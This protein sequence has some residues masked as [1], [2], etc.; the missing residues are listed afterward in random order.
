MN[1]RVVNLSFGTDS[2]QPYQ[3]TRSPPQRRTPGGTASCRG[4]L[5][6]Q[7][8][9][10]RR[11]PDRP[12]DGPVRHRGRRLDAE[13]GGGWNSP[14]VASF[15]SS[16]TASRHV[17]LVAPGTSI[18]SL[19]NPGSYIDANHPSGLV[20]GDT[21]GRLFRGSG[22]SQAAAVV[23]GAVAL[24]EQAPAITP[25]QVKGAPDRARATPMWRA[26]STAGAGE[27]NVA[28]RAAEGQHGGRA[29]SAAC[30]VLPRRR[31]RPSRPRPGT[32]SIEAARGGNTW[33]TRRRHVL[34]RGRRA[35]QAVERGGLVGRR[36]RRR[37]RV[38][39]RYVARRHVDRH[40]LGLRTGALRHVGSSARWCRHRVERAGWDSARWSSAR[41]SSAGGR[42]PAGQ[43]ARWSAAAWESSDHEALRPPCDVRACASLLAAG[44]CRC[45]PVTPDARRSSELPLP[46]PPGRLGAGFVLAELCLM[47][48]EFRRQALLV[49]AGRHPARARAAGAA[50][51][52]RGRHGVAGSLVAFAS[53][54][55]PRQSRSTTSPA[56]AF[57]AALERLCCTRS[58]GRRRPINLLVG[59][60]R[61][62]GRGRRP[63]DELLRRRGHPVHRAADRPGRCCRYCCRRL[64]CSLVAAP[65]R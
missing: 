19:R 18:T 49:H 11:P 7:R 8:G 16:G 38:D 60:R 59:V 40:R 51:A 48:V 33:S 54:A 3:S 56:Y 10:E 46:V 61:P 1:V 65:S 50:R 45:W 24:L 17:D 35:G 57:E 31:R 29:S 21:T 15:S 14:T 22:T 64:V 37:H 36:V 30:S 34:R 52:G 20:A 26:S 28:G 25:D 23:S 4:R 53:N 63:G 44:C 6:R 27:L 5:R 55:P 9:P 39:G 2:L 42:R 47:H 41:W 12:G 58:W 62:G 13:H 32:G 43:P